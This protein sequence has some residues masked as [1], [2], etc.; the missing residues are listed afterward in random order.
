MVCDKDEEAEHAE[1]GEEAGGTDQ[2]A[3]TPYKVV[4]KQFFVQPK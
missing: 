4:A 3:R 2:K 1:V